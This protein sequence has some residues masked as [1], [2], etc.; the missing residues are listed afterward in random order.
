[1]IFTYYFRDNTSPTH[2][3]SQ[4][5]HINK[6][7]LIHRPP[8]ILAIELQGQSAASVLEASIA[9]GPHPSK[10]CFILENNTKREL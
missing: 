6:G 9:E 3:I 4:C 2:A 5:L 1:M 7:L 10:S 8:I